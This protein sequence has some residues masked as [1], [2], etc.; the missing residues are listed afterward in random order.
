MD[1]ILEIARRRDLLVIED[2]CQAHGARYRGR[3]VGSLGDAAAFS[4]YPAKNLG[5]CGDGGMVVTNDR[6]LAERLRILRNY[7]QVE[8]YEHVVK[9][10]NR[11]LDT[12]QAAILRA[13]LRHLDGWNSL[14][15]RHAE[16]YGR[17]LAETGLELP[18]TREGAEHVWH[19]Y[20]VQ[21]EDRDGLRDQL[22][23][24]R[25]STGIHYPIPIHLLPAYADLGHG[26]G[27]FPVTER[28]S[29]RMLSLPM[30]PE[31]SD[32]ATARVAA[33]VAAYLEQDSTRLGEP[34]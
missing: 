4:F 13:K 11:R 14:R 31:L 30:F 8:K 19:L 23:E 33:E 17:L 2:A 26:P 32:E 1:P 9:G 5:A 15:R 12:V 27:D 18:E 7:G 22:A 10:F 20:V 29:E 28:T 21:G 24:Q 34:V 3:R 16:A 6:D 25:I